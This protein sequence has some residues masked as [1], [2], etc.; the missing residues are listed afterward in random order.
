MCDLDSRTRE[1]S[2]NI[3]VALQGMASQF[4]ALLDISKL[5]AG[6][7]HVESARPASRGA[8]SSDCVHEFA[9]VA[10]A[11]GLAMTTSCTFDGVV[12]TD[13]LLLERI[14]R[15]LSTTRSST[16]MPGTIRLDVV[17]R[18]RATS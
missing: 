15:N 9:P 8:W 4:D 1:I 13:R 18:R 12:E 6:V 3:N 7:V 17:A 2:Q 11:K 16:P 10:Q 14:V 5:D